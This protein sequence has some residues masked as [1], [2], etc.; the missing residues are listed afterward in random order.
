MDVSPGNS[1]QEVISM[2]LLRLEM[3]RMIKT[4]STMLLLSLALLLS[5]LMAWLPVTFCDSSY[6]DDKENTV[7]LHG[8]KAI[9][10]EKKLQEEIKG[11]VTPEKVRTAVENYQSCLEK[12][13]VKE[14]LD[15]P[16]GVYEEEI[17]PY[18]PLL[19]GVK[20][21]FA[22][23]DTGIGASIMDIDPEEVDKYYAVCEKRILSL[24]KMEQQE[25]PAAQKVAVAMYDQVK[26]TY[27]IYPGYNTDA[28]DYQM[29]LAYVLVLLCTVIA[30]PVFTSD[31]Q[32]GADDILRC[33]KYGTV[34][35]AIT[36]IMSAF[37]ISGATYALCASV[38]ILVSNYL[39]G[40]EC[41][42]TS[43]QMLFSIVNLPAMNIGQ[44]Q[45][46]IAVTGLLCLLATISFT[47]YLSSKFKNVVASLSTALLFC[48]LPVII[49][50]ALPEEIG[51][52]IYPVLPA[53]GVGLQASIFYAAIDFNFW[54]IG[55]MA[56]WT[57]Y[58]MI[59][60]NLIEIPLFAFL[61]IH[62]YATHKG[63]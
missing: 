19:H 38:S 36:K 9:Q 40:W 59:A 55:D 18:A 34:K 60:A 2:R 7:Q 46:F 42:K 45:Y 57:P 52:W 3:K 54:N 21:A 35:L 58:V 12:Y 62:S 10:H 16:E 32:T 44:M 61:T 37:F 26:K 8:L 39:F 14:S 20:E 4:K 24:M 28:M 22:D 48:V 25:Y 53:S 13:G 31:Y 17:L 49:Y 5:V 23:P 63:N 41:T 6:T 33:T 47:L 27:E 30:A 1:R 29:L 15:L 11:M 56:I 50:M 43:I 51:N